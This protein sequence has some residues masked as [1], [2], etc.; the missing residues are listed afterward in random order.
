MLNKEQMKKLSKAYT[1][2]VSAAEA[3]ATKKPKAP[4]LGSAS[5][6]S[7]FYISNKPNF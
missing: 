1:D 5:P 7:W 2:G 6:L 3:L 4:R